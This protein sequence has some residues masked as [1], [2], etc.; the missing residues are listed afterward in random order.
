MMG[1]NW[2]LSGT[3]TSTITTA[4]SMATV[5]APISQ[6]KL[7]VLIHLIVVSRAR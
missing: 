3:S 7:S 1:T 6:T 2:P 5:R 4:T